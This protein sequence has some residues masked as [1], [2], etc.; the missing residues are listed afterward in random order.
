M[1]TKQFKDLYDKLLDQKEQQNKKQKDEYL[2]QFEI[3]NIKFAFFKN[4]NKHF[5][6]KFNFTFLQQPQR[7]EVEFKG[8]N[9]LQFKIDDSNEVE[10]MYS[11]KQFKQ[12]FNPQYQLFKKAF[13]QFKQFL[14][15]KKKLKKQQNSLTIIPLKNIMDKTQVETTITMDN[16]EFIF[17]EINNSFNDTYRIDFKLD[18]MDGIDDKKYVTTI[19]KVIASHNYY[20]IEVYLNDNNQSLDNSTKLSKEEFESDYPVYFSKLNEAIKTFLNMN[21]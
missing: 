20:I 14:D 18:Q 11:L 2:I 16:T 6:C 3:Q 17:N 13:Q 8:D 1:E 5:L 21:H 9:N 12:Y 19:F 7:V 10:Q 15:S 4:Q